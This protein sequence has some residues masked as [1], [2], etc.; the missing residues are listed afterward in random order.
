MFVLGLT[1]TIGG[2][3]SLAFK[4]ERSHSADATDSEASTEQAESG[5]P[6]PPQG[7]D[8]PAVAG[9]LPKVPDRSPASS[10]AGSFA[11]PQALWDANGA[12]EVFRASPTPA[13]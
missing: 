7:A 12:D 1:V 13:V 8:R 2:V 6:R 4:R 10:S 9:R 3:A 11:T 5:H